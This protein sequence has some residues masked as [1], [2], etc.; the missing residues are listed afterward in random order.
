VGILDVDRSCR[1]D[2]QKFIY[3]SPGNC[4]MLNSDQDLDLNSNSQARSRSLQYSSI[5][6]DLSIEQ[7]QAMPIFTEATA[8]AI[9]HTDAPVAI[10]TAIGG[11]GYQIGSI[12]GLERFTAL[13]AHPNLLLE[14]AG[15]EY[16]HDRIISSERSLSI[17]NFQQHPQ[18]TQSSL[19]RVHGVRAYLGLP[20]VT[21]ARD[22]LGTLAI[23]DF[24]PR[25]FS[26]RDLDLLQLVSRLVASEFERK[27]L[28]QSQLNHWIGNLQ[29]RGRSGFDDPCAAIEH[30]GTQISSATPL[31]PRSTDRDSPPLLVD[32][33]KNS[34]S[35]YAQIQFKL[36]THLAQELRTPLTSVLGMASVLQQEIYG[37]LTGKQKD[38]LGII[39]SSGQQLVAIVDEISQLSGF[40]CQPNQLTLR[41]VD[42]EMLC[43]LVIQS[44][45][46]LAQK[47]QQ[48]IRLNLTD[49]SPSAMRLCLLDKDK[50]RQIVYY[51]CLSLIHASGVDRQI[52]IHLS[53]LGDVLQF[54]IATDDPQSRLLDND[55]TDRLSPHP[56]SDRPDS[57]PNIGQDLHISL[58][59]LLSHALAAAHSGKIES[60]DDRSG[61]RFT[62]PLLDPTRIASAPEH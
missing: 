30:G 33:E 44:L 21:A 61:Y 19:L 3:P 7:S 28:S 60:I 34:H 5:L 47:K 38:Y 31:K 50:V 43:Q 54:Q 22:R 16:C 8:L 59:L 41:S 56:H 24:K 20:I 17:N 27:L 6:G 32:L 29:Y 57:S 26:D 58:G 39:H 15:L 25:Q 35:V 48:Q 2:R 23:L 51:L 55:P 37:T 13:P 11:A 14:L 49:L 36:L 9:R 1:S 12:S 4:P 62:L 52:S 45:E 18:L 42:P 10:L 40:D 46:S 53:H